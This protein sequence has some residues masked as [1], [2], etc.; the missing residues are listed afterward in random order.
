MP[1]LYTVGISK[2]QPEEMIG[3]LKDHGVEYLVDI[4]WK[5]FA[6]FRPEFNKK[7]LDDP[8]EWLKL[9]GLGYC[10]IGELGNMGKDAGELQLVDAETGLEKLSVEV[11]RRTVAIMCMCFDPA[12][13]HR[14]DVANR[15][16]ERLAGRLSV[17]HIRKPE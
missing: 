5:P 1:A 14:S 12:A 13:C 9:S 4:R 15:M 2:I 10:H 8:K 6:R 16:E 11:Q 3:L 17:T 7:R